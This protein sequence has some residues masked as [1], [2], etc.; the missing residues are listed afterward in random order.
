ME[1]RLELIRKEIDKLIMNGPQDKICL[2]SAHIYGI[3]KFCTLLA[4]KRNLDAE[5]AATCGML[6]DVY[7]MI[8]ISGKDH[9][10][11]GSKLAKEILNKIGQYSDEEIKLITTAIANHG[12]KLYVDDVYDELL[13]DADVLDHCLTDNSAPVAEWEVERYNNLLDEFGVK[14]Q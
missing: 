11:K 7:Y 12:R 13:K 14:I 10:E 6:H 1:S 4:L 2:L 5:L 8:D 9:A 3:S